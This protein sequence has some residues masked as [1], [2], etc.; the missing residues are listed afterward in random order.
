MYQNLGEIIWN[1]LILGVFVYFSLII[2]GKVKA[3]KAIKA[4][5]SP[6]SFVKLIVFGGTIIFFLLVL[7][8]LV[9]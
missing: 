6:T 4:F 8:Q 7:I 1:L 5:E 9:L 2:L 3:K